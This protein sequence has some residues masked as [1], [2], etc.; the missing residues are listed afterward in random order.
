MA[1]RPRFRVDARVIVGAA[2]VVVAIGGTT[3]LVGAMDRTVLVYAAAH[4]LSV[5]D[6]IRGDDLQLA[7]VRLGDAEARYLRAESLPS[8][9]VVVRAVAAGELVP[10]T[11]IGDAGDSDL[12]AMTVRTTTALPRDVAAGALVDVWSSLR[13]DLGAFGPPSVIVSGATVTGI[14]ESQA[15][16]SDEGIEVQLLVPRVDVAAVLAAVAN[17]DA[18]SVVSSDPGRR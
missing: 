14:G 12:A 13:E 15:F 8:D 5:G 11:A 16:A 4:P 1:A 2:L 10:S 3:T 7:E 6:R 18:I 17:D 9:G